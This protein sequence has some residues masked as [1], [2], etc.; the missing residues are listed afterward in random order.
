MPQAR[1]AGTSPA[2]EA[3]VEDEAVVAEEIATAS[4]AGE[5]EDEAA[6]APGENTEAASKIAVMAETEIEVCLS[7]SYIYG[8]TSVLFKASIH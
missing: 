1:A 6:T 2:S 8:D 3:E 7:L 4:A 5:V